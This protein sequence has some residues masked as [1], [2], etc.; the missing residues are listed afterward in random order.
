MRR[1]RGEE[2]EQKRR[3]ILRG[4]EVCVRGNTVLLGGDGWGA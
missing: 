2:G 3:Y 1:G 4:R